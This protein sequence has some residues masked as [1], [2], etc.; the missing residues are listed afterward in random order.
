MELPL[1]NDTLNSLSSHIAL[2]DERGSI[3]AVNEAWRRFARDNGGD[4]TVTSV[5]ADYLAV[6]ERAGRNGHE[7]AARVMLE[8]MRQLLHGERSAI[9]L[10][11]PCHSPTERRW[12]IARVTRFTREGSV[13]L[14]AA[15]E[16]ITA[17][18]LAEEQQHQI[19]KVLGETL[20][21]LPVGVWILDK[22]G[23]IV[24]GNAAG[25]KIWAGARYVG[26]EQYGEYKGW[27]LSTGRRI[28]AEE[29]AAARAITKGETAIDEEVRIECFDGSSKII[30]NSAV[31]LRDAGGVISGAIIVNQDITSRKQAEDQLVRVN[32]VMDA[33]N[34]ELQEVLAREQ[35][36]ARTDDLTGLT[37]RRHFVELS[38]QLFAVAKRYRMP[39]SVLIFDI[40]RFKQINDEF[41]HLVGD[42]ILKQV[43][44]IATESTREADVLARYGG[45]EFI[46]TMS[47]TA[48]DEALVAAENIRERVATCREVADGREVSVTISAGVAEILSGEDSLDRLIRRADQALYAAKDAGRNCCRLFAQEPGIEVRGL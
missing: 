8:G 19:E 31:P 7:E 34:R 29:W 12:F 4:E 14:V 40:D 5:G 32:T 45:E 11:Y 47:N 44:R 6:C 37:N 10:E 21:A 3:V 41:G 46:V 17:R 48:A 42:A 9:T 22:D 15:H 26:P 35:L 25:Q 2:L 38:T 27:W 39:L 24:H 23:H 18:K 33:T 13:Y 43:A 30:L 1:A 28:A 20:E 16:D 36:K